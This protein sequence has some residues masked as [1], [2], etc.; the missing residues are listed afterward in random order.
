MP[1]NVTGL[2]AGETEM[3]YIQIILSFSLF[4]TRHSQSNCDSQSG[5]QRQ[6]INVAVDA[7]C[8]VVEI[9]GVAAGFFSGDYGDDKGHSVQA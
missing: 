3:I 4:Y 9:T 7:V 8:P 2:I 6:K 1:G 5:N